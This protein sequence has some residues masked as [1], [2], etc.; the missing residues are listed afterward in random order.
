M[1]KVFLVALLASVGG[2]AVFWGLRLEK[3]SAKESYDNINDLKSSKTKAELGE[4][5]VRWGVFVEAIL[6]FVIAIWGGIDV[7]TT[8]REVLNLNPLNA[9][10]R[11][12]IAQANFDIIG[13]IAEIE[14]FSTN[15]LKTPH[16]LT[17]E[18]NAGRLSFRSESHPTSEIHE[19]RPTA[20]VSMKFVFLPSPSKDITVADGIGPGEMDRSPINP[21]PCGQLA[22]SLNRLFMKLWVFPYEHCKISNGSVTIKIN[23]SIIKRFPIAFSHGSTGASFLTNTSSGSVEILVADPTKLP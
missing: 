5:F 23:E 1:I 8:E 22:G 9:P 21:R 16:F 19:I 18:S 12:A 17:V 7:L 15:E 10:A 6:A 3:L 14:M 20:K 4:R 11:S 13:P 2:A